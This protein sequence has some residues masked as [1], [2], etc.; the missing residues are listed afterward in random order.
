MNQRFAST[1]CATRIPF[2]LDSMVACGGYCAH[3]VH[4]GRGRIRM[5]FRSLNVSQR[6]HKAAKLQPAAKQMLPMSR[7]LPMCVRICHPAKRGLLGVWIE[8]RLWTRQREAVQRHVGQR[9]SE[10]K[11]ETKSSKDWRTIQ[12]KWREDWKDRRR[13]QP[14]RL[15]HPLPT[16]S[17]TTWWIEKGDQ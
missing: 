2:P 3:A 9:R 7:A 6:P 13:L 14:T 1:V 15:S 12:P 4:V 16:S 17:S 8:D 10:M 5:C 11:L